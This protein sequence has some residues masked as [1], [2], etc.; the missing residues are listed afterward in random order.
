ME[1]CFANQEAVLSATD[2]SHN[3][4]IQEWTAAV[5]AKFGWKQADLVAC[6]DWDTDKH[7]SE[8]RARYMW[9]YSTSKGVTGTP[10]VFANGILVQLY[11]GGPDDWMQILNVSVLTFLFC[12][13][14]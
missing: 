2:K 12:A 4:I 8:M 13:Q 9:K 6:Y 3:Q 14:P 5:S 11:P 7:N 1:F 10:N